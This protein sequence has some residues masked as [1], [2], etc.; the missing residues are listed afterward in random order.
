MLAKSIDR[1]KFFKSITIQILFR[2]RV[3]LWFCKSLTNFQLEKISVKFELSPEFKQKPL[4]SISQVSYR[5][6]F[7][8]SNCRCRM[9]SVIGWMLWHSGVGTCYRLKVDINFIFNFKY[10][11]K[12]I[13]N[14]K[15]PIVKLKSRWGSCM[16][17]LFTACIR[18]NKK[19]KKLSMVIV[20][21]LQRL[22]GGVGIPIGWWIKLDELIEWTNMPGSPT[23]ILPNLSNYLV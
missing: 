14:F 23:Y 4:F 17:I 10:A 7:F 18:L 21:L 12:I 9:N 20:L 3:V 13:L 5:C 2:S 6:P 22:V 11:K 16:F 8:I 1:E 15:L 19:G